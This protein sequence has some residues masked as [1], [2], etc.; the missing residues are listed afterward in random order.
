MDDDALLSSLDSISAMHRI[1]TMT[2]PPAGVNFK[3][4]LTKLIKTCNIRC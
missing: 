4:L 1:R 2:L 3:L